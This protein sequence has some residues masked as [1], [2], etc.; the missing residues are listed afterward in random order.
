MA[1][2]IATR[3][4]LLARRSQAV[5]A[6][7]GR[8]LLRDKRSALIREFNRL[9]AGVLERMSVLERIAVRSRR[10]LDE[11]VARY[12]E[13][14]I[15]SLALAAAGRVEVGVVLRSVAG[16]Q[17]A[18]LTHGNVGR[19]VTGRGFTLGPSAPEVDAVAARY[20]DQVEAILAVAAL[21]LSLRRLAQ[22]INRTTRQVNA[23]EQVVLPRLR[24]ERDRIGLVLDEREREDL[25]RLRRARDRRRTRADLTAPAHSGDG[26]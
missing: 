6:E 23:L 4:E 14:A 18:E 21:E 11:A 13:P 26:R 9:G 12:G 7:Q 3:S 1:E 15:A 17:V 19:V 10:S 8:D 22:E 16:V 2:V 5:L 24:Q 25:A 20:E